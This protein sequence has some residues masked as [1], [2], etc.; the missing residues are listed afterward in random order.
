MGVS[1]SDSRHKADP[2]FHAITKDSRTL[3]AL[4]VL[5]MGMNKGVNESHHHDPILKASQ[6]HLGDQVMQ[7]MVSP[8][9]YSGMSPEG[10]KY[11]V[12]PGTLVVM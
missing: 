8:W 11:I 7:K 9:K 6:E 5:V 4:T 12:Q 1:R 2:S 10:S 3:E